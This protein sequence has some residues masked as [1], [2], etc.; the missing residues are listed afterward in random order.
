MKWNVGNIVLLSMLGRR[1]GC[2]FPVH[3]AFP[4]HTL[5]MFGGTFDIREIREKSEKGI[6][7]KILDPPNTSVLQLRDATSRS[8]ARL[9]EQQNQ[10]DR[11]IQELEIL[12]AKLKRQKGKKGPIFQ[13]KMLCLE[14]TRTEIVEQS[15][16]SA[17]RLQRK[18]PLANASETLDSFIS[19]QQIN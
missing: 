1:M 17:Y 10:L 6:D 13:H 11:K 19:G 2:Q 3:A 18:K 15:H 9:V 8:R 14:E 16:E 4:Q 5:R 12:L 7:G